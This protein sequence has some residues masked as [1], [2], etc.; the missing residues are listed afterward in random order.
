MTAYIIS[1]VKK[2]RDEEEDSW[3][4]EERENDELDEDLFDDDDF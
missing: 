4:K 3:D 1:K 2:M